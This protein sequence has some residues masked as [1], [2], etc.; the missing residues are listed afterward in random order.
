M[1]PLG[2]GKG[3]PH[4]SKGE[5]STTRGA[6]PQGAKQGA[7]AMIFLPQLDGQGI[8]PLVVIVSPRNV[9]AIQ[10]PLLSNFP[11]PIQL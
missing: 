8:C 6:Q 9:T 11:V 1:P 3:L 10:G 2:V 7:L 4:R 5:I